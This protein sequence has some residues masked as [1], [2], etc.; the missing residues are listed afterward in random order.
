M[1]SAL[2]PAVSIFSGGRITSDQ[3][4]WIAMSTY[5]KSKQ[6]SQEV[7][8]LFFRQLRVNELALFVIICGQVSLNLASIWGYLGDAL[9]PVHKGMMSSAMVRG[10]NTGFSEDII[11]MELGIAIMLR[12][13]SKFETSYFERLVKQRLSPELRYCIIIYNYQH[14]VFSPKVFHCFLHWDQAG[15]SEG[16]SEKP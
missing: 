15:L 1:S 16:N 11:C 6:S 12:S 7:Y 2:I 3:F 10:G 8:S 13:S 5:S 14:F 4:C 9:V